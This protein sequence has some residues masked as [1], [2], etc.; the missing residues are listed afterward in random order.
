MEKGTKPRIII[1]N[2]ERNEELLDAIGAKGLE[3]EFRTA[4]VGDYIISDRVC[5]ERKTVADFESSLI[6]GRLFE[7]VK[8][9]K[10]NYEL[11]ILVLEGDVEYFR[12]RNSVINGAIAALYI[13]YGIMVLHTSDAK[14]TGE[15]IAS[16][17]KHEH[18]KNIR[19]PSLKGG[20]RAYT[21]EQFQEFII[22]NIP[23]IG[24]KLARSLLEH[25]KSIKNIANAEK[26]DLVKVEKIGKKKAEMIHKTLNDPYKGL[27][28][29]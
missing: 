19:E 20:A 10:E 27:D 29:K 13:D 6:N 24:S 7:Q 1:D 18:D 14:S 21:R 17:A 15:V 16:M 11:P 5:I 25:F 2:R 23:G 4:H 8:R 9:L 22:G 12:L 28:N 26:G 3:I